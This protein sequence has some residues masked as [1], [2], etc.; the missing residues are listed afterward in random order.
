MY[1]GLFI[2]LTTLDLIYQAEAPPERNQK[3]VAADYTVSAGGPVT[4]AAVT[5]RYLGNRATLLSAIGQHPITHLIRTDLQTWD[6]TIADL[7]PSRLDPPP[8]SSIIVTAA[9]GERAVVSINAVNAQATPAEIPAECLQGVDLVLIDGHQM[10][11]GRAIAQAAK[12]RGIPVAIDGGSWKPGFDT[13]LPFTDYAICSAN[14][15]PPGCQTPEAV[16]AYLASLGVPYSA[17]TQGEQPIRYQ[18][19]DR[20]GQLAVSPI[21][22]VDTVGAGDVFHGSF[23]HAILQR[24]FVEAL[25]IAAQVAGQSCQSFGTR[26][27][28]EQTTGRE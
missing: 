28:M 24:D 19:G 6:V 21:T 17:I 12:A 9:T 27:W 10:A 20:G 7:A 4:N 15:H 13:V 22:A 11:V 23:C 18:I 26:R 2:G 25:A 16:L 3:I 8:V 1:H 5:F 14:F